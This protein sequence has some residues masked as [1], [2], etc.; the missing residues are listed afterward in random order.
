M[1]GGLDSSGDDSVSRIEFLPVQIHVVSQD[2]RIHGRCDFGRAGSLGTVTDDTGHDGQRIDHGVNH[3]LVTA[4][5]KIS[6]SRTRCRSGTHRT[7]VCGESADSG[8]LVDGNQVGQRQRPVGLLFRRLSFLG[9]F[10]HR[11]GAGHSLISASRIDDY[12]KFTAVHPGIGTRRRHGFRSGTHVCSVAGQKH[13][14]DVGTVVSRQTFLGN[15]RVVFNLP[16]DDLPDILHVH[17][18]GKIPNGLYV[19][20]CPVRQALFRVRLHR[21]VVENF[22]V[23]FDAHD[24]GMVVGNSNLGGISSRKNIHDDVEHASVIHMLH[25]KFRLSKVC[26]NF[27]RLRF[28]HIRDHFQFPGGIARHNAGGSRCRD[29]LQMIGMGH[30]DALYV[31]DNAAAGTDAHPLRHFAQ[32][33]PSFGRRIS[34]RNR[35]RASHGRHQLLLQN[36]HIGLILNVFSVHCNSPLIQSL[37]YSF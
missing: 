20:Q 6:D 16:A 2:S 3:F 18:S 28:R 24:I 26:R 13:A 34:Q 31:L 30:D 36:L 22:S 15:R 19:Q 5:A 1:N 7:A 10:Q 12:R 27:R 25:R 8:L 4:A 35:F 17:G 14:A 11:K 29:S 23:F 9:I 21:Y 32:H 37:P 33:L